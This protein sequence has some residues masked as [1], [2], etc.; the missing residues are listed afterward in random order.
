MTQ[1]W[2]PALDPSTL[3]RQVWDTESARALPGVGR[4]LGIY[5][6]LATCELDDYAGIR[7]RPRP[8]LLHRPDPDRT[9]RHFI[10]AHIDDY[11]MHG[12]ALHIVTARDSQGWPAACR[13]WPAHMWGIT[14]EDG[15]N[16]YWLNGRRVT[17]Q[18]DVVHNQRGA[19]PSF[20]GRG[21][22]VV[23]QHVKALN[24]AGLQDEAEATNLRGRG[25][26]GVAIITPQAEPEE[27]DLDAAADKWV[28][29]FA[30]SK[31]QPAFLPKGT[32]VIPLAWSPNDQQMTEARRLTLVDMANI[33]NLDGYWLGAPGSSHTY[34]STGPL[35]LS[36]LRTSLGEVIDDFEDAWSDAWLPHGRRVRFDRE[37]LT[38]EDLAAS[39]RTMDTAVKGRLFTIEEARTYLGKDPD[40]VPDDAPKAPTPAAPPPAD[41]DEDED[42]EDEETP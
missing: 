11:L 42:D 33:F 19:D 6:I 2:P 3:S 20:P 21:V 25:M 40:V 24:R 9:R 15:R 34:K 13:W 1:L 10:R 39:I 32:E 12:N 41:P 26:P 31:H 4:A 14:E 38:I 7:P 18:E 5:G 27:K 22:G 37:K 16:V 8:R 23:E 30:A 36:L 28:E 35:F 29:K 17:R